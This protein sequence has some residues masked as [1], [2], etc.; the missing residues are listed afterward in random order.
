MKSGFDE[1]I[2]QLWRS[3]GENRCA[4]DSGITAVC[5]EMNR[6]EEQSTCIACDA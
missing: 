4:F 1:F 5:D 6:K 2:V 3:N